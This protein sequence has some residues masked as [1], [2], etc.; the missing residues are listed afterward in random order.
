[1]GSKIGQFALRNTAL[2][3]CDMQVKFR[4]MIDHF[5]E[6]VEVSKRMFDA[7]KIVDMP[8]VIT[9]QY[10]KGL[11]KTVEELGDISKY[12]VF[13]KTQFN[14]LIPEVEKHLKE[15]GDI[16]S[17]LLCGIETHV[18]IHHTTL[19]LLEKGY[20]V[21]IIADAC[22]SRNPVDRTF[23]FQRLR[24]SGA[25][26]TTSESALLGMV[27]DSAHPKFRK[28]QKLVM[29]KAPNSHLSPHL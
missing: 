28:V 9:E 5:P 7:A 24:Q 20:D 16:K 8:V 25:F 6:T 4:S 12:K 2:F 22:S 21:H 23:A 27:C 3:L 11:G 10:P 17:I 1:M 14:M 18:C 13:E 19:A 26:I 15:S 29:E